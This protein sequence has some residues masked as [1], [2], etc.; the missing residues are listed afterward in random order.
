MKFLLLSVLI[1]TLLGCTTPTSQGVIQSS[2]AD[3]VWSGTLKSELIL[4]DGRR[5]E[6]SS[7][8]LIATCKGTVQFWAGTGNGT[9]Q[10][11]GRNYV[12][13]S[14]PNTHLIYFLDAEPKQPDWV[15]IQS[16]A[17]LEIDS[18]RA[19]LQWS[20][21]VNNRD[22]DPTQKNRYFFSQGVTQLHR[23][24]QSCDGRLAP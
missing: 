12:V 1:T 11:L 23:V 3:G 4:A 22:V 10:K 18:E 2:I 13:R 6:G 20:R 19:A 8:L 17:L 24:S 15:E 14:Y 7:D 16:Y 21:A 9:Y 5:Q